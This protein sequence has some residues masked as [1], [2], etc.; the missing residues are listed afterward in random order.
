MEKKQPLTRRKFI[1][2]ALAGI[3]V[4]VT[5]DRV[6][7]QSRELTGRSSLELRL[8]EGFYERRRIAIHALGYSGAP[9]AFELL[10]GP[11]QEEEKRQ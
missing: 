4:V 5:M 3:P 2:A 6:G 1:G 10:R 7:A 9:E 8:K 11:D